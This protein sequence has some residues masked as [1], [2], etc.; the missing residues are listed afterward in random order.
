VVAHYLDAS[1]TLRAVLL[2]L[3]RMQ[4]SHT[5]V[6]LS[7]QLGLVLRYYKLEKSFSNAIT[8]NASENVAYLDLLRDELFIDTRKRHVQC[9]GYIINLVA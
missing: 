1:F 9:T 7:Q 8:D 5:A 2:A 6:N 3:L 4:G